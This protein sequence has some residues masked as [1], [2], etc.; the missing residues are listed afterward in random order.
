MCYTIEINL[1]REQLEKR[2]KA[3]LDK[4]L[5]YR[6]QQR[7]NA[8]SLPQCPVIAAEDPGKIELYTWGLIPSW[9]KDEAYAR[10]IRTK[11]FN[12]R[13]ES[14]FEKPSFR[15]IA[16]KQKC[17]VLTNGF[18]EWQTREKAK[19]PYYIGLKNEEAF[20]LAGLYDRWLNRETGEVL[21]T[22]T[23]ITTQANPMMEVI[24]NSKKR[25]PVIIRPGEEGAWVD[26]T[27]SME[28]TFSFLK[29]F[30][31]K[32]MF[33]EEIDKSLFSHEKSGDQ[34]PTLF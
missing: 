32:L 21:N 1:T 5:P 16:Q 29:P 2:F 28:K 3:T 26:R 33:A 30:D 22:F 23:V 6:K 17:L 11:T 8:F 14:L 27:I 15:H 20:A 19:Q 10:S 31:E 4:H 18:Y 25:M 12:A 9:V 13:A 24:H 34:E 7:A